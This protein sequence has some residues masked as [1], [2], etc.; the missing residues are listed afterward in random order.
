MKPPI[1]FDPQFSQNKIPGWQHLPRATREAHIHSP[2]INPKDRVYWYCLKVWDMGSEHALAKGERSAPIRQVE[3]CS[4][5]KLKRDHVNHI[6]QKLRDEGLVLLEEGGRLLPIEDPVIGA[7]AGQSEASRVKEFW[8]KVDPNAAAAYVAWEKAGIEQKR[9]YR[10]IRALMKQQTAA[11]DEE[12]SL[13][14]LPENE[15]SRPV[16]VPEIAQYL[17]GT[18]KENGTAAGGPILDPSL[19]QCG[20][21]PISGGSTVDP[22]SNLIDLVERTKA[23]A[24]ETIAST[25]NQYGDPVD[26]AAAAKF[27]TNCQ[28][29][30]PDAT[31]AE[32]TAAIQLKAA[33]LATRRNLTNPTGLLLT[34]VPSELP[35]IVSRLR[36]SQTL[37]NEVRSIPADP[38]PEQTQAEK[39]DHVISHLSIS[40]P[41]GGIGDDLKPA[42]ERAYQS[43]LHQAQQDI[44]EIFASRMQ[45]IEQT[46]PALARRIQKIL[47]ARP[48]VT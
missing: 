15:W 21:A 4:E 28:R 37:P 31:T 13:D 14:P 43:L 40:A 19:K 47:K 1:S 8:A 20:P 9:A 18:T 39:L 26:N 7:D 3:I 46:D 16:T 11:P 36:N 12:D 6:V 25:L 35:E 17:N 44:P 23:A 24:R 2:H 10:K 29:S 22:P 42:W 30:A 32:I 33:Q 27:Y 45:E 41:V 38:E 5:L 34:S 48:Y